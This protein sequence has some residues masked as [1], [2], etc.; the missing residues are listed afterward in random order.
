MAP[1]LVRLRRLYQ[2]LRRA[3]PVERLDTETLHTAC[4]SIPLMPRR[5]A[6][7]IQLASCTVEQSPSDS[8]GTHCED[9]NERAGRPMMSE[10]RLGQNFDLDRWSNRERLHTVQVDLQLFLANP[11]FHHPQRRIHTWCQSAYMQEWF[12]TS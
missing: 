11:N 10:S 1:Q 7:H 6:V 8:C 2:T 3:V 9:L 4:L 5:T 12:Q